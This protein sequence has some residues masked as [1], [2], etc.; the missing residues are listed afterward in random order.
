M[1]ISAMLGRTHRI[2]R[3]NTASGPW[4][5]ITIV[6]TSDAESYFS[7]PSLVARRSARCNRL[8]IAPLSAL[9]APSRVMT[10]GLDPF[11]GHH[12]RLYLAGGGVCW[13][14]M[15]GFWPTSVLLAAA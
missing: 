5:L 3:L 15:L 6:F 11:S 10:L 12:R 8:L 4:K 14:D 7:G 2:H 13:P 9:M 1:S